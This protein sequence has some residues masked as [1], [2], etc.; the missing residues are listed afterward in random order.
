MRRALLRAGLAGELPAALAALTRAL[1][2]ELLATLG[3][4]DLG[5]EAI[6][7]ALGHRWRVRRAADRPAADRRAPGQHR[8]RPRRDRQRRAGCRPRPPFRDRDAAR[9]DRDPG[10]AA[11]GDRRRRHQRRDVAIR[12]ADGTPRPLGRDRRRGRRTRRPGGRER[13]ALPRASARRLEDRASQHLG[14]RPR[15]ALRAPRRAPR[16]RRRRLP[17]APSRSACASISRVA[18]W[19]C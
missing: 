4:A 18:G 5:A 1:K 7:A 17:D 13:R 2:A 15:G 9:R 3:V 10:R 19:C 16:G 8:D 11:G 12:A 14:R 6:L